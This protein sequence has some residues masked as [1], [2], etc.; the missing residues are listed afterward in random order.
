[1]E[2]LQSMQA[3]FIH[4]VSGEIVSETFTSLT[5]SITVYGK[6]DQMGLLERLQEQGIRV[7]TLKIYPPLLLTLP[8]FMK[9]E[10]PSEIYTLLIQIFV[11]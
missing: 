5:L 10:I 4:Q 1:M 8:R 3:C 7:I 11:Q 6:F 2:D 9:Q